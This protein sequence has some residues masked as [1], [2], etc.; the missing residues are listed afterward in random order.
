MSML[1]DALLNFSG[2]VNPITVSTM[3]L[4]VGDESLQFRF[5]NSKTNPVQLAHNITYNANTKILNAP[6]GIIQ[7][8]T[9]GISSLSSSHKADEYKYWDMAEYNSPVLIDPVKKYYLYA[10]VSKENQTGTFLLSETAIKME[11]ITGYYHL[12]TGVLNSEYD[13]SRSFVELYGFTEILP[14][15]VTTERIISPDGKTYFDLV[16]GEIGGNIQIKAGSSGLENLS[17]WE[18]AHQEIKD[19]AKAAKDAADSVEGL[20]NYVDGA[21]ADGL[22][23]E[24]EAKAIEKY[25]NT[26]NNT[27]QAIE[28]TYNKLYTN[29][30]LSGSAKISLLNAKVTL[31]GSIENLINAINT[32]I[33]DGQATVE[34]KREVDN[35]FTLFN[36]ALATFNTAVEEANKA[37]QDKLKEYSDEALKQA[38]Q[39]LEDAANAA[40]AA[41][42]AADSVDGLHDYVD[43]AFA[44]GIIDGAEAKAIEVSEYS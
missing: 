23:D 4:L 2:S 20:H 1:E 19:A 8:L 18:D 16:K 28:A 36:S 22:I 9:L 31:M 25:I 44:D 29:V 21:F 24:A 14:G 37:I 17:E 7:H 3:Q 33:A 43:G 41:Q 40:K 32:V 27:K 30:Y 39:A 42:D 12:L 26:I 11:Q 10:K 35:K 34:E 38:I 5:V 13:G 15:R 6:A